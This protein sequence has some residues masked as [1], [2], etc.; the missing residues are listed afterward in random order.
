MART[1]IKYYRL[2]AK[3]GK[4]LTKLKAEM[5][6]YFLKLE[7]NQ[8]VL[9]EIFQ[10]EKKTFEEA[11]RNEQLEVAAMQADNDFAVLYFKQIKGGAWRTK[12]V[13]LVFKGSPSRLR[14][15]EVWINSQ[16]CSLTRQKVVQRASLALKIGEIRGDRWKI[17]KTSIQQSCPNIKLNFEE[18]QRE[19]YFRVVIGE[20]VGDV[21]EVLIARDLLINST[22]ARLRK[23]SVTFI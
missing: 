2:I 6:V 8:R 18:P 12:E 7:E 9:E 17:V 23:E 5:E 15:A 13:D 10:A 4:L 11:L 20:I 22:L 1:V 19:D 3:S 14:R 16:G 21:E